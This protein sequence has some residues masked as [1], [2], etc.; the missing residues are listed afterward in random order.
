MQRHAEL[1]MT[2]HISRITRPRSTPNMAVHQDSL[3][4]GIY[5][6]SDCCTSATTAP[7]T[8]FASLVAEEVTPRAT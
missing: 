3:Q 1:G 8:G 5:Y 6:P 2:L 4:T 7:S